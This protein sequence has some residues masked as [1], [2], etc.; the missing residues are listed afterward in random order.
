MAK[1]LV[2]DDSN[3]QRDIAIRTL[4]Q[5]F[6]NPSEPFVFVEAEDGLTARYKVQSEGPF[7][8]ILTDWNMPQMTGIEL[9]KALD[10]GPP[11]VVI[12]T[13]MT[14][15]IAANAKQAGASG[16]IASPY[17]AETF[18]NVLGPILGTKV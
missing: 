8:L 12:G 10:N 4:Q 15:T 11:S 5:A 7:D 14:A 2:V 1:I 13:G 9:I 3:T 18:K 17:T 6:P 16:A